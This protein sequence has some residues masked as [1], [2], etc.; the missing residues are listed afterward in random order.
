M[1]RSESV[2]QAARP[3]PL[4]HC[5]WERAVFLHYRVD[6]H[7]LQ[8]EVPFQLDLF[9]DEA[10]VSL[11]AFTLRDL[12]MRRAGLGWVTQPLATHDFLN[13]RTYVRCGEER[14]IYFLAEWLN[15]R[16]A[17]FLG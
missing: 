7:V 6:A 16:L 11:V 14:G 1:L 10:Y 13:V 12:R 17:T 4:F 9:E 8:G 5:S 3:S 15:N 2:R